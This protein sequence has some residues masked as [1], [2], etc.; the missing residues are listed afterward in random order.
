MLLAQDHRGTVIIPE[1]GNRQR[2]GP[3]SAHHV[4]SRTTIRRTSG[5]RLFSRR[6]VNETIRWS[7]M[8]KVDVDLV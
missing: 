8:Q 1:K 6:E 7:P 5:A 4:V 2:G 3:V